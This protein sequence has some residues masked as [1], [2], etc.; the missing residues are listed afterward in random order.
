MHVSHASICWREDWSARIRHSPSVSP[1]REPFRPGSLTGPVR[2]RPASGWVRRGTSRS[3]PPAACARVACPRK[4]PAKAAAASRRASVLDSSLH[5]GQECAAA[6]PRG[7]PQRRVRPL[8]TSLLTA[9]FIRH[10]G[11]PFQGARVDPGR[12]QFRLAAPA[13]VVCECAPWHVRVLLPR[14]RFRPWSQRRGDLPS[15]RTSCDG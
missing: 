10:R 5:S 14:I 12:G 1:R 2:V 8:S 9:G 13:I 3:P 6:A 15:A 7:W 11:I 4:E